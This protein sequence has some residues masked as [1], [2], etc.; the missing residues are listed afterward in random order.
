MTALMGSVNVRRRV[1]HQGTTF[2]MKRPPW[3]TEIVAPYEVGLLQHKHCHFAFEGFV[4]LD[5]VKHKAAVDSFKKMFRAEVDLKP[6]PTEVRT[7]A[8]C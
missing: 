4:N 6:R 2:L 7:S 8:F 3:T 5:P 1:L